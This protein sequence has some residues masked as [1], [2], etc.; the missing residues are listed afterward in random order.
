[1]VDVASHPDVAVLNVKA[2]PGSRR[3]AVVGEHDGA[4]KVAVTQPAEKGKA[5]KAV[6]AM[7]A[8]VM[9]VSVAQIELISGATSS[10][11]RFLFH[12]LDAGRLK[13]ALDALVD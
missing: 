2:L 1:M 6:T 13:A 5:N 12:G 4:L 8:K 9:G 10:R 7:L 11:K 3:N